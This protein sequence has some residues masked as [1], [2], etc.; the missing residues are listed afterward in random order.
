MCGIVHRPARR[1]HFQNQ[2]R[3]GSYMMLPR[4]AVSQIAYYCEEVH[5]PERACEIL[6]TLANN[7][8]QENQKFVSTLP[9]AVY[10]DGKRYVS[11]KSIADEADVMHLAMAGSVL[12]FINLEL[13]TLGLKVVMGHCCDIQM[14]SLA[15]EAECMKIS[16]EANV[17]RASKLRNMKLEDEAI[18]PND[19]F[20]EIIFTQSHSYA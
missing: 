4:E 2:K 14:H 12:H 20:M 8:L 16:H 10:Q 6:L 7:H 15:E 19:L 18:L 17:W 5:I 1:K 9:F 3:N 13:K 11:A